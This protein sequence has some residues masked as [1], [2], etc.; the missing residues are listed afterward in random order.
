[1]FENF[2]NLMKSVGVRVLQR[3]SA[4]KMCVH[5]KRFIIRHWLMR[6]WRLNGLKSSACAVRL[7]NQRSLGWRRVCESEDSLLENSLLLTGCWSSC[8]I[9]AS[10]W[11]DE[12]HWHIKDNLLYSK[13]TDWTVNLI[14]NPLPVTSRK[15]CNQI[16]GYPLAH[17]SWYGTISEVTGHRTTTEYLKYK[18]NKQ[19]KHTQK[20]ITLNGKC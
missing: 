11:L 14:W 9:Q 17:S 7:E 13:S 19:K 12:A 5:R 2:Q 16:S 18:T 8:S 10:S 15:M 3:N 6:L 4:Y 1:M 20:K